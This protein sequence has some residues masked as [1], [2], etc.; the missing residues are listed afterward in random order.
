MALGK[1]TGG[2]SRKGKPNRRTAA[3]DVAVADAAK[4]ITGALGDDAFD[5]DAHALLMAVYKDGARPM[6]QRIDAAKAAIPYERPRLSS[7]SAKIEGSL[8]LDQLI[9]ESYRPEAA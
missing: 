2:G 7:T 6:E 9:M 4:K 1:K 3:R 5:G 8:S